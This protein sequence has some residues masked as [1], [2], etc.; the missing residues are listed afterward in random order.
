MSLLD[1]SLHHKNPFVRRGTRFLLQVP[2]TLRGWTTS[3][4]EFQRN[5]PTLVNSVPKSGTHLLEQ[6]V[7]SLPQRTNYGAFLTSMTSSFVFKER[8][9]GNTEKF[10]SSILPNELVRAHLFHEPHIAEMLQQRNTA[11]FFIYRDPRD[12]VVSEAHYLMGMNRWHRMHSHFRDLPDIKDAISLAICGLPMDAAGNRELQYPD[13]GTRF[14]RYKGWINDP[15]TFSVRYEELCG[16]NREE[17][18]KQMVRFF[19]KRSSDE[20]D[21][22]QTASNAAD[23]ID[24]GKSHTFRKGGSGRWREE[25]DDRLTGQFK[26]HAGELLIELGYETALD[27]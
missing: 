25:F 22:E 1:Q 4:P 27:W 13:I 11:Q 21:L 18:I 5:P 6:I 2:R 26:E 24:S 17:K 15:A 12:V 8:T 23:R 7:A 3:L 10:I 16:D 9:Q 20:F 19:A 14:R